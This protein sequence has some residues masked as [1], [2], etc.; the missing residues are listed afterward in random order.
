MHDKFEG[1][2]QGPSAVNWNA[3]KQFTVKPYLLLRADDMAEEVVG[4][5]PPII[6]TRL[7][8][9]RRSA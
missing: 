3:A 5:M 4:R 8:V 9:S 2:R 6:L 7:P 1:G